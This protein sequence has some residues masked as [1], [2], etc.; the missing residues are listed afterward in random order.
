MKDATTVRVL[1]DDYAAWAS[2]A[3]RLGR[4]IVRSAPTASGSVDAF[5]V[6][7]VVADGTW[8]R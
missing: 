4:R 5:I 3:R 7:F 6:T 1:S 8:T 2:T